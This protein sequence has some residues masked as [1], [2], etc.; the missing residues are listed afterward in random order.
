[1][2]VRA[3]DQRSAKAL[4]GPTSLVR[5]LFDVCREILERRRLVDVTDFLAQATRAANAGAVHQPAG[6]VLHFLKRYISRFEPARQVERDVQNRIERW[7]VR[8]L[9]S[10]TL[11]FLDQLALIE[12]SRARRW[13]LVLH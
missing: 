5:G 10:E 8:D 12:L 6:K 1:M 2:P 11:Q 3:R 7:V 13:R 9:R 4:D